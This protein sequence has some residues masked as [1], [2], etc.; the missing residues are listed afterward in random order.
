MPY[1]QRL[2]P[3]LVKYLSDEHGKSDRI[4]VI[5]CLAETFNQCPAA[6]QV[7]FSDFMAVLFKHCTSTDGSLNRNVSY[8]FAICA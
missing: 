1:L 3:K 2:G 6:L 5:G 7:Y 4:M 8:A